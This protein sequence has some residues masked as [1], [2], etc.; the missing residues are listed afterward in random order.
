MTLLIDS[1]ADTSCIILMKANEGQWPKNYKYALGILKHTIKAMSFQQA[2][3]MNLKLSNTD[4][5]SQLQVRN[6]RIDYVFA[7]T[8]SWR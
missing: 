4:P 3:Y 2:H 1:E 6:D 5:S 7:A 8:C